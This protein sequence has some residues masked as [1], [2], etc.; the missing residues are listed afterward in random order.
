MVARHKGLGDFADGGLLRPVRQLLAG[1]RLSA[2]AK[3]KLC[4]ALGRGIWTQHDV[5]DHGWAATP[6]DC[7]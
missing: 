5:F 1:R 4:S 2:L 7:P 6:P 3:Q